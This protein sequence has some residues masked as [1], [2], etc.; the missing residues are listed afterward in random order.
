MQRSSISSR[1]FS[2]PTPTAI[3]FS[4]RRP[5]ATAQDLRHNMALLMSWLHPDKDPAGARAIL[6]ARVTRA[7][8][9]LRSPDRRT[10]YDA[11]LEA[12]QSKSH[13]RSR[14]RKAS[15]AGQRKNGSA[16][17]LRAPSRRPSWTHESGLRLDEHDNLLRR[18]W[19]FLRRALR[20]P[21][22]TP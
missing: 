10:A 22:A 18:G 2:A 4:A 12:A 16:L 21:R 8:N 1:F 17:A 19:R 5:D 7:W 11:A 14:K 15:R 13:T 3:A 20:P 9:D 6:A